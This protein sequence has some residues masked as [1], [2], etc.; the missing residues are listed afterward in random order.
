M[1]ARRSIRPCHLART[2]V[3]LWLIAWPIAYP[4]DWWDD[5]LNEVHHGS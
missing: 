5:D 2:F 4:L 1:H 3:P